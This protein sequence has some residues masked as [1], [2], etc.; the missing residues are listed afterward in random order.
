MLYKRGA[1]WWLKFSHNGQLTYLST[2]LGDFAAAQA[3]ARE[4]RYEHEKRHGKGGRAAGVPLMYLEALDTERSEN[5]GLGKRRGETLR[6]IWR[7]LGNHL[8]GPK[9]DAS[10]LTLAEL[11]A[12]EGRRRKDGAVGQTIRRELQALVRG[13]RLAKRA[14]ALPSLPFDPDDMRVIRSDP[15]NE[16]TAGKH[17][18]LSEINAIL[19]KLSGK[20]KKAHYP[21][22]L[23]LIMGTGLRLEELRS[24]QPSWL[25]PGIGKAAAI[26]AMPATGTK[27]RKP[28]EVPLTAEMAHTVRTV[29]PIS[30]T[31][32]P[33]HALEL[34]CAAAGFDRVL[35]PRD[36]RKWYLNQ[37]ATTDVLAAQRLAG[38]ASIKTTGI[39]VESDRRRAIAT[40]AKV[41]RL[42]T[43]P[44]DSKKAVR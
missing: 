21:E 35:T 22:L 43:A 4:L 18:E 39:Y 28:R 40:G 33:N 19:E 12:Y 41:L 37:A 30:P 29:C 38:H 44:G 5:E 9:R 3:K 7:H 14:T 8:G 26:L 20:A 23:R 17:W 13:L 15:K 34:A 42:V 25:R 32:K 6:N 2:G 31:W 24:V 36:L 27:G 1:V 11:D 16:R 10:A